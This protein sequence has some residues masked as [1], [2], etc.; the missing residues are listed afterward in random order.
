MN[1]RM[2]CHMARILLLS[3][4]LL[5]GFSGLAQ[6]I[7]PRPVP[8]RLVNDFA[9][10]LSSAEASA[11]ERKL[12]AYDDTTSIQI[13][14]ITERSLNGMDDFQR[15]LD[16]AQGWGVGQADTDNGVLV[17]IAAEDRKIRILTG[18]GSEGFLPDILASRIIN[19]VIRPN[20]RNQQYFEGLNQATDLIMRLGSGEYTA[21]SDLK[22]PNK[23]PLR[24][25]LLLIV[26][27][28]VLIIVISSANR[29]GGGGYGGGGRY[30][31]GGGWIFFG[32][33]HYGGGFGGGGSFGGGGGGFGGF[34]GGSFGGGGAGGSW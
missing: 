28:I 7:P 22:Q 15:A 11:L 4:I 6:D 14:I 23:K 25:G 5:S 33:G 21:S 16:I 20:F 10:L 9:A 30:R 13:A 12:V 8:P 27:V 34:G 31:S 29:G 3:S 1:C 2:I 18:E 19:Q 24:A 26:L 32:P 17:Y